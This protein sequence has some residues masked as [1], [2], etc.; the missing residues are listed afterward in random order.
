MFRNYFQN[1]L[2]CPL[3]FKMNFF[4][5]NSAPAISGNLAN[6]AFRARPITR[7]I[8]GGIAQKNVIEEKLLKL[9]DLPIRRGR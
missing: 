8:R 6:Y 7:N 3:Y 1:L 9:K 4:D 5:K 2:S